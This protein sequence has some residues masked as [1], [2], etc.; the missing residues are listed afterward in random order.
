LP[1]LLQ[2][3]EELWFLTGEAHLCR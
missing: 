2:T 3:A 1:F